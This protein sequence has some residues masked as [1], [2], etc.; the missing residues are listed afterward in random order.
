MICLE[1][2][3]LTKKLARSL[4]KR[5]LVLHK[6]N[7][8]YD[9]SFKVGKKV[10]KTCPF[11][12]PFNDYKANSPEARWDFNSDFRK[13]INDYWAKLES[14]N[15]DDGLYALGR[16]MVETVGSIG[17]NDKKNLERYV[18]KARSYYTVPDKDDRISSYSK[19]LAAKDRHKY[20]ILDTRVAVSLNI[21]Q[22]NYFGSRRYY[23][24]VIDPRAKKITAFTNQFPRSAFFSNR[25]NSVKE[26]IGVPEYIFYTE[27]VNE[28]ARINKSDPLR[29]EE[30][31]FAYAPVLVS[32]LNEVQR[33]FD[34]DKKRV[35]AQS[36]YWQLRKLKN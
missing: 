8:Q 2:I 4:L 11:D 34:E 13:A 25:F 19:I 15:D 30:M 10:I 3:M 22:L 14:Q 33:I 7:F 9:T 36:A 28:M 24:E 12:F 29:I 17:G 1:K 5:L 23:I 32:N 31:L 18:R 27:L 6:E 35:E 21:L 26:T 16:W 20:Q